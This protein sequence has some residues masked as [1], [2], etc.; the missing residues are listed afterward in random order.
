[1]NLVHT[2]KQNVLLRVLYI[3]SCAIVVFTRDLPFGISISA[4]STYT[5][6]SS[7]STTR[8]PFIYISANTMLSSENTFAAFQKKISLCRR[9]GTW[10]TR[11]EYVQSLC[12]STNST[13]QQNSVWLLLSD[14]NPN[15]SLLNLVCLRRQESCCAVDVDRL[16]VW[17]I[18]GYH[19]LGKV[20]KGVATFWMP[21]GSTVT[22]L[23][24]PVLQFKR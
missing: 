2:L 6:E 3:T 16:S 23:P 15:Q 7:S 5:W 21:T 20:A 24:F 14:V 9:I 19:T 11:V 18:F 8:V 4:A 12:A 1:M 22:N 10:L 13:T 17:M